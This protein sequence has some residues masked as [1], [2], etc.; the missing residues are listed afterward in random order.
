[1]KDHVTESALV[2]VSRQFR[3]T[4]HINDTN[5]EVHNILRGIALKTWKWITE[6]MTKCY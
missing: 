6:T 1:M 3:K 2:Q 5:T 4:D